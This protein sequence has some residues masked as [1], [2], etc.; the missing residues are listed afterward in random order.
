MANSRH[1]TSFVDNLQLSSLRFR[2]DGVEL[3]KA[4]I[5]QDIIELV[6]QDIN[7]EDET[8]KQYGVRNLEKRFKSIALLANDETILVLAQ[9]LLHGQV[10]LVRAIY[11]D[12]TP[13]KNWF[14]S[15]HQDKT[16]TL[17]KKIDLEGWGPWSIKDEVHH[18]QVP[19]SVLNNMV[20]FRLH[21]DACDE[22]NG[23]LKV[24]PGSQKLGLLNQSAIDELKH[25]AVSCVVDASDAVIMRPHILHSSSKANDPSHRRVVH[26]EYSSF[27]L[28]KGVSWA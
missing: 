2:E 6:K 28:P 24:V 26:L 27:E 16:V 7:L 5:S 1:E 17:N 8:L 9:E 21:I 4:F 20:T 25:N 3:R 14:V 18:V 12:K 19:E 10:S 13:D 23:C 15:W 22:N 11:F